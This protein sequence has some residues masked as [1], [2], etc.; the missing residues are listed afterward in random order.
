MLKNRLKIFIGTI[1]NYY[2]LNYFRCIKLI[3]G[4]KI[5]KFICFKLNDKRSVLENYYI[6]LIALNNTFR[7]T[8]MVLLKE[9][10]IHRKYDKLGIQYNPFFEAYYALQFYQKRN[11]KVFLYLVKNV[12]KKSSTLKVR[13]KE[14]V[15]WY[16]DFIFPPRACKTH[17]VSGIAQGIIA[18]LYARAYYLT[19]NEL[20]RDL[21]I[22]SIDGMLTFIE[23]GGALYRNKGYLWIEEYPIEK[24][25]THVLNGFVFSLLGLYDAYL[26]TNNEK[27]LK[28]FKIF[29]K[30]LKNNLVKYDLILWSKYDLFQIADPLYHLLHIILLLGLYR[31]THDI[32]LKNIAMRWMQGFK[33]LPLPFIVISFI[34]NTFRARRAYRC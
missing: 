1:F 12:T 2:I 27:Y 31:L 20:Y 34:L 5:E 29:I 28:L 24:P 7:F 26:I 13:G 33:I 25:L 23:D 14:I 22:K 8:E 6:D 32:V 9:G 19:K 3:L 30:V 15:L 11:Y 10:H 4:D 18:S 17:W 21:C 16:Y